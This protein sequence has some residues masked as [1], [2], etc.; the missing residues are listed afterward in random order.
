MRAKLHLLK[1]LSPHHYTEDQ[2]SKTWVLGDGDTQTLVYYW[3]ISSTYNP[4][5]DLHQDSCA[6]IHFAIFH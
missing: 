5:C 1:V 3:L 4:L 6:Y 2:A